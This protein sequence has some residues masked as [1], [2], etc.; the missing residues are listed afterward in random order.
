MCVVIGKTKLYS[1]KHIERTQERVE[2]EVNLLKD[3][4]LKASNG[5]IP[6]EKAY[7][8]ALRRVA[9]MDFDDLVE[10]SIPADERAKRI[11]ESFSDLQE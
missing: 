4:I 1:K 6:E 5:T 3:E 9:L 2:F 11:V 10:M 7:M 8:L